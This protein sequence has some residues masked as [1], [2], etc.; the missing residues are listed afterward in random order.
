MYILLCTCNILFV[1]CIDADL[2]SCYISISVMHINNLLTRLVDTVCIQIVTKNAPTNI[3]VYYSVY[4]C[5]KISA[6]YISESKIV[7]RVCTFLWV[8]VCFFMLQ[9]YYVTLHFNQQLI[10]FL[11][12]FPTEAYLL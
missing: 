4:T 9:N 2:E 10:Q 6:E 7:K 1:T 8:S 12:L 3:C 11:F 5:M